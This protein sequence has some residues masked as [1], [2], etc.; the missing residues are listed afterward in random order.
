MLVR[1][2]I[3]C[4]RPVHGAGRGAGHPNSPLLHQ[5]EQ[6]ICPQIFEEA[7]KGAPL[8]HMLVDAF[9]Q[10]LFNSAWREYFDSAARKLTVD[11]G[12]VSVAFVGVHRQIIPF[13]G[14]KLAIPSS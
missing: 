4:N 5:I 7:P 12:M 3:G 11:I 8:F 14:V 1:M 6:T 9:S 13:R 2:I 10:P